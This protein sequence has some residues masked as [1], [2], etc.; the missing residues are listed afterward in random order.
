MMAEVQEDNTFQEDQQEELNDFFAT[1]SRV[2]KKNE[3][4][5]V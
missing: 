4:L 2:L 1:I 3:T 5:N